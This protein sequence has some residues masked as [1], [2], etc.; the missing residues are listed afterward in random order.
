MFILNKL[1]GKLVISM[2]IR[3]LLFLIVLIHS[4]RCSSVWRH[5]PSVSRAPISNTSYNTLLVV[6]KSSSPLFENFWSFF[7]YSHMMFLHIDTVCWIDHSLLSTWKILLA[8]F[9]PHQIWLW[10]KVQ[11]HWI[12]L[13]FVTVFFWLLSHFSLLCL[14]SA[15]HWLSNAVQQIIPKL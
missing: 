3:Y 10:W 14:H 11:C 9:W 6:M 4:W 2:F 15:V 1:L 13:L 7:P 5:F 12:F 8:L